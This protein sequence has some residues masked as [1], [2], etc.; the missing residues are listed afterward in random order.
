MRSSTTRAFILTF[1]IVITAIIGLQLY[2][3]YRTYTFEQQNFHTSVVKS[4]RGIYEDID[5]VYDPGNRMNKLVETPNEDT[6]VFSADNIPGSDSLMYYLTYEFDDFN[7]Y[8]DC[9]TGIH[10]KNET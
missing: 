4:I 9:I 5:M 8:T 2:W 3:L 10:I 1:A 7:V 6:Y